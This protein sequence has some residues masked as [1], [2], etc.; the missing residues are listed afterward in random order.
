MDLLLPI[1]AKSFLLAGAVL[2][3]LKIAQNRSASDDSA[4][5]MASSRRG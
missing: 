3:L 1:A 2:L 4:R 5:T